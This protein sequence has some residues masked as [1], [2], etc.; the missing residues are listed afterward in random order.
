MDVKRG[1]KF[2]NFVLH[3]LCPNQHYCFFN[4]IS[5]IFQDYSMDVRE[6]LHRMLG[7]CTVAS[8][9]CL[10]MCIDKILEN[11]KRY[12]QVSLLKFF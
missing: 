2:E 11:L 8:K 4:Y 12:P 6:G 7:S 9:T 5:F 3:S 10:E 1:Q